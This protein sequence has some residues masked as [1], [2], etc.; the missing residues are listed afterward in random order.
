MPSAKR[1]STSAD[2]NSE[3]SRSSSSAM[4]IHS[5]SG[6]KSACWYGNVSTARAQ[7]RNAPPASPALRNSGSTAA[8]SSRAAAG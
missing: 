5:S 6:L 3:N 1:S 4:A 8:K 7:A 2:G